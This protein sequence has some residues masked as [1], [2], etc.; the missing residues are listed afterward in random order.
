MWN[1]IIFIIIVIKVRKICA[2]WIFE[3]PPQNAMGQTIDHLWCRLGV[4]G[5]ECR[6]FPGWIHMN[7]ALRNHWCGLWDGPCPGSQEA[8]EFQPVQLSGVGPVVC[9]LS[10]SVSLFAKWSYCTRWTLEYFQ[11]HSPVFSINGL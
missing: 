5:K 11:R 3:S 7:L 8:W 2:W 6:F 4:L 1:I 10:A 9:P